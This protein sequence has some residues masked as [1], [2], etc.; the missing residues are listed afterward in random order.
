MGG[1]EFTVAPSRPERTRSGP[2]RTQRCPFL[3]RWINKFFLRFKEMLSSIGTIITNP[4]WHLSYS[5][6][7]KVGGLHQVSN[8]AA[9]SCPWLG[10]NRFR[11]NSGRGS[12]HYA[13]VPLPPTP[14][15]FYSRR[16]WQTKMG[17]NHTHPCNHRQLPKSAYCLSW[18]WLVRLYSYC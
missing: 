14:V 2:W 6:V 13:A 18:I 9:L 11:E 1:I 12:I 3:S 8:R 10:V 7:V 16:H 15:S 17:P 5:N 4:I